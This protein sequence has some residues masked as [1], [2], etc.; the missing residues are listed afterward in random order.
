M[1]EASTAYEFYGSPDV[2]ASYERG[3]TERIFVKNLPAVLAVARATGRMSD[4]PLYTLFDWLYGKRLRRLSLSMLGAEVLDVACGTSYPY[5]VLLAEGWAGK[6]T[7]MDYSPAML[8][9][10][11]RQLLRM[12]GYNPPQELAS[13]GLFRYQDAL[14]RSVIDIAPPRNL[15]DQD[16]L[17]HLI[18][19]RYIGDV[20]TLPEQRYKSITSFSGPFCFFPSDEQGELVTRVCEKADI[21]VSFQFKNA[22]FA[23]IDSSPAATQ[24][25]AAAITHILDNQIVEAY[26]F[27]A[28]ARF[29]PIKA[30]NKAVEGNGIR[31]EVGRFHYY[32]TSVHLASEWLNA[33]G[34]D[35]LRVGSMGF[36]S[37]TFFELVLRYY[38]SYKGNP[39]LLEFLFRSIAAMDDYF[40][41]EMLAGDN[42]QITAV[43][44]R[45]LR[46][47][48]ID[49]RPSDT[50]RD[51]YTVRS[52]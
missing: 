4:I 19:N 42:L 8:A 43:R 38:E 2:A 14:G 7:G 30:A 36:I 6:I 41:T 1:L 20:K 13:H 12:R 17:D 39:L 45:N 15:V 29:Q 10:G 25:V 28:G 18:A 33:A 21:S 32:P 3:R 44:R 5:R 23:A 9:E 47:A 52:S 16:S 34:F 48:G 37:Q 27:L 31:H 11:E 46:P 22:A 26:A 51:G 50:F 35:I 40:C 24:R 49:Y